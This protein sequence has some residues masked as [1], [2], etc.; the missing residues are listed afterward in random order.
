MP[1]YGL[2]RVK[3]PRF[4]A[5]GS[6][7]VELRQRNVVA[8]W[9]LSVLYDWVVTGGTGVGTIRSDASAHLINKIVLSVNGSD[10]QVYDGPFLD[11]YTLMF[12]N[13]VFTQTVPTA[14]AAATNQTA[15]K[16]LFLLPQQM[17]WSYT[18][19]EFGMPSA[20]VNSPTLTIF[21]N[22]GRRLAIG[23]DGVIT[24][25][26]ATCELFERPYTDPMPPKGGFQPLLIKQISEDVVATGQLKLDLKQLVPGHELRAI[27]LQA[28]AGGA[29]GEDYAAND[30][31]V[32]NVRFTLGGR[33]KIENVP[34]SVIQQLNKTNY[35][36]SALKVGL[37]VLDAAE[38]KRTARGELWTVTGQERPYLE[39]DVVKQAG[40]NKVVITTVYTARR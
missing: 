27:F 19:E 30:S 28:Y 16:A 8:A 29:A 12:M 15:R 6:D 21:W 38:D 1:R 2:E 5:G 36:T 31:V 33:A 3:A 9:V 23:S 32:T 17:G 14:L 37:A 20:G 4:V 26:N 22:S 10:V 13:Q 35:G 18:P 34:F 25:P 39:L 11:V 40:D 24:L 7:S